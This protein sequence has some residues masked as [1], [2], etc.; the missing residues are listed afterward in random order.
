MM[1]KFKFRFLVLSML[2]SCSPF[3]SASSDMNDNRGQKR[4]R[5]S[6]VFSS[7]CD[8]SNR[9]TKKKRTELADRARGIPDVAYF[10]DQAREHMKVQNWAAAE[11]TYKRALQVYGENTPVAILNGLA[12][13]QF[14]QQKWTSAEENSLR[15]IQLLGDSATIIS[16]RNIA[17]LLQKQSKWSEAKETFQKILELFD[18]DLHVYE[19]LAA[20]H[21]KLKEFDQAER[22][23]Q[24]ALELFGNDAPLRIYN[25][26]AN[27]QCK[28]EEL[29][30][31]EKTLQKALE[32]FGNDASLQI[33]NTL[34]NLQCK[35][36]RWAAAENTSKK[37]LEIFGSEVPQSIYLVLA[38]SQQRQYK[39]SSAE[40]NYQKVIQLPGKAVPCR[41]HLN[42]V[43][44]QLLQQKFDA[45][46]AT[47][48]NIAD[49]LRD[50]A[51]LEDYSDPAYVKHIQR[52]WDF[53]GLN[54][55]NVL[56]QFVVSK[57][58]IPVWFDDLR[59]S[60]GRIQQTMSAAINSH[61]SAVD[62][63]YEDDA[64]SILAHLG[65][66]NAGNFN[67]NI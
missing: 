38:Y 47:Y 10:I 22:T 53:V 13:A 26:L 37:T 45:A 49:P 17:I 64:V 19:D 11:M 67:T 59:V 4:T 14:N 12:L 24:K 27:L 34:A 52:F 61:R 8:I 62:W 48:Q 33:Y 18:A 35:L 21:C 60:V 65:Q 50:L 36:G 32:L 5:Q 63:K 7:E 1:S 6:E 31:A 40:E 3:V 66:E 54:C 9:V 30:Q 41:H 2:I 43:L 44:V 46:K 20:V 56:I 16:Y 42:L 51:S 28:L 58:T 29:D 57:E 55:A 25:T 23:L 15:V 39:L